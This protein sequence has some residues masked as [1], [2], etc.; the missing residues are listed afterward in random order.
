LNKLENSDNYNTTRLE[1]SDHFI[2]MVKDMMPYD[3]QRIK[4]KEE[5][6]LKVVE[7]IKKLFT[8]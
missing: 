6:Y 5:E 4:D 3:Y 7:S 1:V 8:E 2:D